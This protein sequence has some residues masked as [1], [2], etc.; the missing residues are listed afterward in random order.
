MSDDV[1]VGTSDAAEAKQ[2]V[3][4]L[5]I[6]YALEEK[7]SLP[8][9]NPAVSKAECAE[10]AYVMY[11]S[12]STGKPKGVTVPHRAISRLVIANGFAE[13]TADDVVV[14]CSNTAFD[15]STLEVWGGI[16]QWRAGVG[17]VA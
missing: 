17:S 16:A 15:A 5:N 9:D 14:H 10:A 13:L 12:G 11:T 2:G 4:W 3:Q 6:G 8:T 7:P 1:A